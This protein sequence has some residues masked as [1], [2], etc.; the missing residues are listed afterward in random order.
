M[1]PESIAAINA[2]LKACP[3]FESGITRLEDA[4]DAWR[5]QGCPMVTVPGRDALLWA[6]AALMKMAVAQLLYDEKG[7]DHEDIKAVAVWLHTIAGEGE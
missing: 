2:I 3:D 7:E 1:T 6:S 5:A 4:V